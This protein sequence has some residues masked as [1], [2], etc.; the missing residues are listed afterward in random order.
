MFFTL[1]YKT[2]WLIFVALPQWRAGAL[3]GSS[4]QSIAESFLALP[5][6]ALVIPWGYA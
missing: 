5:L 4:A 2:I 1:G 3:E 6:L